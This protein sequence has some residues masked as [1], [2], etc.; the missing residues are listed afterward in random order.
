[1]LNVCAVLPFLFARWEGL[2]PLTFCPGGSAN[3]GP[4]V[5]VLVRALVPARCCSLQ[6]PFGRQD[7]DFSWTRRGVRT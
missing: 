1:M 6:H 7:V 3:F 4:K 2:E 5:K